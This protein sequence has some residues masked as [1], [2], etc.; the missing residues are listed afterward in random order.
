MKYTTIFAL[1][2]LLL[3]AVPHAHGQ[4]TF[5][6]VDT[7][8]SRYPQIGVR[9]LAQDAAGKEI[10][11][12]APSDFTVVENG[13]TRPVIS[14]SCPPPLTPVLS[15]TLT[16]DL[17][18]SM[19]VDNRLAN[20]KMAASQLV[21]D[22][23]YPP[24]ATGITTFSDNPSI[25]LQ[26]T[27]DKAAIL[28]SI[29]SMRASGG[30]TDFITAFMDPVAGAIAFTANRPQPRYIV[31]IT[32]AVQ[33]M[34]NPQVTQIVTAARAANI[35]IFTVSLS[36]NTINTSLRQIATQTQGAWFEDVV[37]E[38][39]ARDIFKQ[40]GEQ[41]FLYE[42][43]E[44]IYTTDGCD[45]ERDVDVTLRKNNR[46]VT[47][48]TT[49][50]VPANKIIGID[51]S[52]VLL[53]YGVV[54]GGSTKDLTVTLTARNGAVSVQSITSPEV[55]FRILD[56]GGTAPPFT[57]AA[58]QSRTLR[59]Q[60]RPVNTD[61]V[62]GR[63]VINADSPCHETIAM[64]GGVY[65]PG[66]LKLL[67]P[68]GGEK[69]FSGSFFRHTWTGV[70][71]TTPVE[72]EYST[73]HGDDWLRISD[74]VYNYF[75]NWR[76]ANTPSPNCLG[77]VSTKEERI[78]QLDGAWGML[79]P[80]PITS[81]AVAA[82]GTL[83]ALGLQNGQ[84]KLFYPKDGAFITIL[85]GHT[86]G[87]RAL[88]FSPDMR[89]LA[90]AGA[91]GTVKIWDMQ[92]ST[93]QRTLTGLAGTLHS[94]AFSKDGT[95]LAA[96]DA[97][98]V[99]LWQ[100]SNWGERWRHTGDSGADGDV[101]IA[102]DNSY[103]ASTATNR[104]A[105][106]DVSNGSRLRN[107]TGHSGA[108]RSID[109]AHEGSVLASGSDDRS[110][111]LWNTR[112]W[113][114]VRSFAG[115]SDAVRSV[116]LA[117]AGIRVIS[118]S[119]DNSVR[120]WESRT[121]ALL[122][123]FNG[124]T[125]D[126]L[127]VAVDHRLKL[128]L[129]GGDDQRLRYWGYV[130]P[131]ADKSDDLWEIIT[132]VSS[133][134][135]TMPD[136]DPL[137]CPDTW[138]E[139]EVLL[140]NIGNQDVTL[141]R[142]HISGQD[143]A[144]FSIEGGF[145]IPPQV[146]M[147]PEDS[148]RV[149]LRFFPPVAGTFNSELIFE[150]NIPGNPV[151]AIPLSGRKDTVS[152]RVSEDTLYAGEFY[153]CSDAVYL[154]LILTNTGM[155]TIA[156]DSI[157]SSLGD[158]L[159]FANTM[160]RTMLPGQQDTILVRVLPNVDGPFDGTLRMRVSPCSYEHEVRVIGHRLTATP[161]ARPNPVDFGFAAIGEKSTRTL[162]LVNPAVVDMEI[163]SFAVLF[164]SPPFRL[165]S[166]PDSAF[167]IPANDSVV[168]V[169]EYE[170]ETE[171]AAAGQMFFHA[172]LPCLDSI[173]VDLVASSSRKP[174]IAFTK[175][176]FPQLVCADDTVAYAEATLRNTG[177]LPLTISAMRFGGTNGTDFRVVSPLPPVIIPV[178]ASQTFQLAFNTQTLRQTRN[179]DLIVESDAENF[180]LL[181]IPFSGFK[182]EVALE[183]TGRDH[184][185]GELYGC[186]F[187]V[188]DTVTM[189][190][191]GSLELVVAIDTSLLRAGYTMQPRRESITLGPGAS[192]TFILTFDPTVFGARSERFAYTV[193]P[194]L[195]GGAF[196]YDYTYADHVA[197][198]QPQLLDFG[199]LG[200]GAVAT[201]SF[202]IR[203]PYGTSMSLAYIG[204]AF[205]G[206]RSW[207]PNPLPDRLAP[208][209]T[210]TITLDFGGDLTVTYADSIRIATSING[211]ADSSNVL[212][213]RGRVE[214][215]VATV[216]LPTLTAAIGERIT[217]PLQLRNSSN[218]ALTATKSF[219]LALLFN[220]SML[221]P[222]A[223]SSSTGVATMS[224]EAAGA[225]QR[226]T[227]D[228]TQPSSPQDG[229]LVEL[230]CLVLL[231]NNDVTPLSIDSFQWLEGTT[232]TQTISGSFT[233][234]GIC[235]AGGKRLLAPPG[236]PS[237]RRNAPNPFTGSTELAY[238][239]PDDTYADLRVYNGL[240]REVAV[241]AEGFYPAG[242]H[243][244][245]FDA[246]LLPSGVYVAMLRTAD[247]VQT[248]RMVRTK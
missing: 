145:T 139:V 64:S 160:P 74:N 105:I 200:V 49:V 151:Y 230:R 176:D 4:L 98:T 3:S 94:V 208:G 59:I 106:L 120:I 212:H 115:H 138:S 201:R 99:I 157:D 190:N 216:E 110:V 159:G 23:T 111:R 144:V 238:Y 177:G 164:P 46:T 28:A 247:G 225:Y 191:T 8:G 15:L 63:L 155:L 53:D 73:N 96:S 127:A 131:L 179:G 109:I 21:N 42:P 162:A 40:I 93:L 122:H 84:I 161:I 183:V 166:G 85:P 213:L 57:L 50:S 175:T 79:Q 5:R 108:V 33:I 221:W 11:Q 37:T 224:V 24:A 71:G 243:L 107:L 135:H 13:I 102:P 92:T 48:N 207:S 90:S 26:Y 167:I 134:T 56:Y 233:A 16:V 58:G 234:T 205:N 223:V 101:A 180:P 80:A 78:T 248:L 149:R 89:Q 209:A 232:V 100:T 25:R 31:F 43:C 218:L 241:L 150:T 245:T 88:A 126:V 112:T 211:C 20:M 81:I 67:T 82:S 103:V 240:G 1:S 70:S 116:Q 228:V 66:P 7:D 231:G 195:T 227:I 215:S 39:K 137:R 34:T 153:Q 12:Y 237:L 61:R 47:Q 242:M 210:V 143:S 235:E 65:D 14:V 44:L 156:V 219:R 136:F 87:T 83:T 152:M 222:E 30:G 172:S 178:G 52:S 86:G 35:K 154:P 204:T 97:T 69:M 38:A 76:V 196:T 68:N 19:T 121:G 146:L 32:D 118:A 10:R 129:S 124:H 123:T 244:V 77:L 62:Y 60:Y 229:V 184:D 199:T 194:C 2:C 192:Q 246:T 198:V 188:S 36:P 132:T 104:I 158:V 119:R 133:L 185:Y 217:I 187:P 113:Q 170:P 165:V 91:D 9:F 72:V 173:L 193:S 163:D 54:N 22:L 206:L 189:R 41:I 29:D 128:V 182:H 147:K 236:V 181:T 239:L 51:A 186:N 202:T 95:L 130:P 174:S 197:E 55:A 203:N 169:F 125:D 168:F 171:G 27:S 75:Y 220:R 148:L 142:M 214:G 141:T 140:E 226:V 117:N 114:T 18:F 45:T 6:I 17:S